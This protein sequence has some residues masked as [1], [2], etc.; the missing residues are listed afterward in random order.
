MHRGMGKRQRYD[1]EMKRRGEKKSDTTHRTVLTF[2]DHIVPKAR[3]EDGA[4][5]RTTLDRGA[6]L[7]KCT[8]DVSL[9]QKE[10]FEGENALYRLVTPGR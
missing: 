4:I 1:T 7:Q 3:K 5:W 2:H 8:A 6:A 9:L 10:H